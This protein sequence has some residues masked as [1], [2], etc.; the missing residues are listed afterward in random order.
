MARIARLWRAGCIIRAAALEDIV[1][2]FEADPALPSLL[3]ARSF[4]AVLA[5]HQARARW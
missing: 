2:A 4:S 5:T 1:A 3:A